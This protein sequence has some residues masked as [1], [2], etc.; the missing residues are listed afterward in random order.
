MYLFYSS[1]GN[2]L[3]IVE[4]VVEASVICIRQGEFSAIPNHQYYPLLKYSDKGCMENF[5]NPSNGTVYTYD[6]RYLPIASFTEQQ[7]FNWNGINNSVNSVKTPGYV[8]LNYPI[9]Y[10]YSRHYTVWTSTCETQ[11]YTSNENLG[12]T[13]NSVDSLT[14]VHLFLI[15]IGTLAVVIIGLI[16]P[17]YM[18][19]KQCQN[20]RGKYE[21]AQ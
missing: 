10:L 6:T 2:D 11:D 9:Y 20:L 5:T 8:I 16:S 18:I 7:I 21:K 12:T 17:Y 3:P 13:S 4:L 14:N 1:Q 19:I 15:F